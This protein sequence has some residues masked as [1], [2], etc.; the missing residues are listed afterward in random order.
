MDN[1]DTNNTTGTGYYIGMVYTI[2]CIYTKIYVRKTKT[3]G[4]TKNI[5]YYIL[6]WGVFL[7][8]NYSYLSGKLGQITM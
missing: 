5:Y 4:K 3:K 8:F 6:F 2:Y 1:S 7:V